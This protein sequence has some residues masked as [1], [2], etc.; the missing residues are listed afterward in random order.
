MRATL[1]IAVANA[2]DRCDRPSLVFDLGTIE[3]NMAAI[4][5]AARA[6]SIVPLFAAK[7]F[8]HPA[9]WALAARYFDGFDAASAGEI[10]LLPAT[11][12]LS[13]ADPT[14]RGIGALIARSGR[15]IVGCETEA[16]VEA[17]PGHAEIAIRLSAS[18]AGRDPAIGAVLDGSGHRRSRFG[19]DLD[20]ATRRDQLTAMVRAAGN[21]RVG[22]HVHHGPI[23]ATSAERFTATA[24]AALEVADHA[25]VVPGFLNLG[26]AWHAIPELGSAL[27][28]VRAAVP[29]SVELLIEPGRAIS[30]AAG[31][32]CGRVMVARSLDDRPLRVV[33]LSRI[34]H[35]RWSQIELVAPAPHPG[36]GQRALFVGPTCYEED[37]LGEWTIEP[38]ALS[39]RTRVVVRDVSGYAVAWNTG[40]GG[41]APAEVVMV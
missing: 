8:P 22:L 30:D 2:I 36:R 29:T 17:A 34:C 20:P 38:T 33:D 25:G 16:Q 32:A 19:L 26:G 18:L 39:T 6:A 11:A 37:V 21:R 10:E 35:L 23:T 24:Q 7:S 14:G 12:I 1:P 27:A 5:A 13:V 41:I 31:F 4:A 9:I 3:A 40:F 15:L 28:S